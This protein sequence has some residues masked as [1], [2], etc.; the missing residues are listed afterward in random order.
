MGRIPS[1]QNKH[2]QVFRQD[3]SDGIQTHLNCNKIIHNQNLLMVTFK[4]SVKKRMIT[5][6]EQDSFHSQN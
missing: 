5:E 6:V 1:G 3:L 2:G 4:K